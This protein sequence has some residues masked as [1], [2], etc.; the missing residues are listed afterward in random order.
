M[1][2]RI[3]DGLGVELR[4]KITLT[5]VISV[6][7]VILIAGF[8]V[9]LLSR[10]ISAHQG[11]AFLIRT[12]RTIVATQSSHPYLAREV[13]KIAGL[14]GAHFETLYSTG[15]VSG[16]VNAIPN[17]IVSASTGHPGEIYT[18]RKSG[19]FWPDSGWVLGLDLGLGRSLL[20]G[21][22]EA[23]ATGICAGWERVSG[24]QRLGKRW[25]RRDRTA[26]P[27]LAPSR[28]EWA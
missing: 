4:R 27:S 21:K 5:L 8:G 9:L 2:N 22:I 6:T 7:S 12:V 13:V 19:G 23:R 1:G 18:S 28:P 14:N 17:S 15:R 3:P 26:G 20:R 11:R 25:G 24:R 16:S 10:Q